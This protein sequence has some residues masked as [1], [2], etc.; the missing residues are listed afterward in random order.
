VR[1][2]GDHRHYKHPTKPGVVTVAG[3]GKLSRDIPKGTLGQILRTAR[4]KHLGR[5]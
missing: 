1:T 5:Q 2:T 3:G 4:L